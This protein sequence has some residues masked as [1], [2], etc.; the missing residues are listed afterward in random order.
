[1]SLSLGIKNF[2]HASYF[3]AALYGWLCEYYALNTPSRD[4]W[5][6][7]TYSPEILDYKAGAD[8]AI[9]RFAAPYIA[10]L[11]YVKQV[12]KAEALYIVPVPASLPE[13]DA[14]Y[15]TT[16]QPPSSGKSRDNRNQVFCQHIHDNYEFAIYVDALER[17]QP[18]PKK[19]RWTATQ[20]AQSMRLRNSAD[21]EFETDDL[22]ILIDDVCTTAGTMDGAR[23]LLSRTYDQ[24]R[25]IRLPIA[26]TVDAASFRSLFT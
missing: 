5:R 13:S 23:Q 4:Q 8:S 22:L 18:K 15:T 19:A 12:H 6:K 16:P 21:I 2:P 26:N 24:Q 9:T 1:M 20:H 3:Q 11:G 7:M 17:T 10:L 14:A 25:I